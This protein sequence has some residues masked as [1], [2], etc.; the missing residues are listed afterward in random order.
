M[1][2]RPEPFVE[3]F[4]Y[5]VYNR[6]VDRQPI[7]FRD[8]NYT[9]FA[10]RLGQYLR[11]GVRGIAYCLMP[12]HYHLVLLLEDDS[13][14]QSAMHRLQMSYAKAVNHSLGRVGPLFQGR[15]AARRVQSTED[16][17]HLS[18]YIHLNPVAARIVD[19]PG[20]W[21]HSSYRCY[22]GL[23][24]AAIVD[25]S[26]L[27]DILSP[28]VALLAQRRQYRDFVEEDLGRVRSLDAEAL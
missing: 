4:F 25:P 27:L 8:A 3:G 14:L 2:R 11:P 10:R 1:P 19:R 15:F 26:V 6:G 22:V 5:H 13:A 28:D 12:N 24:Q 16:L 20:D 9:F 18:R 21:P 23:E 7:F 17:L